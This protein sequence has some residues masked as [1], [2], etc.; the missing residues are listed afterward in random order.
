MPFPGA[1]Q[2]SK[3]IIK[4]EEILNFDREK[5][6]NFIK[7]IVITEKNFGEKTTEIQN[8]IISFYTNSNTNEEI[9]SKFYITKYTQVCI[10]FFLF[11]SCF[12]Q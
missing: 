5:L 9:N 2:T 12:Y 11:F 6:I 10:F 1:P 7:T 8:A 3:F 4:P